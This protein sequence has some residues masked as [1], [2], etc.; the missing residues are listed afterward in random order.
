MQLLGG[1]GEGME[2]TEPFS[3]LKQKHGLGTKEGDIAVGHVCA[4]W[5]H[6]VLGPGM[7]LQRGGSA[8]STC[9]ASDFAS[10]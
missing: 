2:S 5:K 3:N 4:C 6:A 10:S 8:E 1:P 7:P 9:G